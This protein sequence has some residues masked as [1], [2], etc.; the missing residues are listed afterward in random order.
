MKILDKKN[1]EE[2]V[3]NSTDT[4]VVDFYSESCEPCQALMPSIVEFSEK[5]GD[6]LQFAK[7]D[8]SKARRVAI[9]QK[10]LG[11]PVIAIYK[12]G[13]K[14]EELVKDDATPENVESM[15]QKYI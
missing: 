2:E 15:I 7:L 12:N 14:V 8:T 4:L 13:E 5:Y 1:F 11:L 6:Q 9:G 10:I 3:L